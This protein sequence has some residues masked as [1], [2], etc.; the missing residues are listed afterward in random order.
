MREKI[1]TSFLLS[2][3][4]FHYSTQEY[5]YTTDEVFD[6]FNKQILSKEEYQ[7]II[8]NIINIL[9]EVYAFNEII[10]NPPQ[11]DFDTSYFPKIDFEQRLN[12]ITYN[13]ISIYKFYQSIKEILS[14]FKDPGIQINW[15]KVVLNN[16]YF[17]QPLDFY[18]KT[19]N[20]QNK[21]YAKCNIDKKIMPYFA[22][23]SKDI[24]EI[25]EKNTDIAISTINGFEP[26]DFINNFGGNYMSL[27]SKHGTFTYKIKYHNQLQLKYFPL[28]YEDFKNFQI[29]YESGDSFVTNYFFVS[30]IDIY[31]NLTNITKE[32][33][34]FNNFLNEISIKN[35]NSNIPKKFNEIKE[36]FYK[37]KNNISIDDDL[38]EINWKYKYE[39]ILRC[40][41]DF[42]KKIN[43]YHF[44]SFSPKDENKYIETI[45]Q[46]IN[47]F[48]END[49]SI[50]VINEMNEG[51]ENI[52][53]IQYLIGIISPFI[54]INIFGKIKISDSN[55]KNNENFLNYIKNFST[56]NK[57][58]S[59]TYDDLFDN[60]IS[61]DK[62]FSK[63]F[64][65]INK[66]ILIKIESKR[67]E[68]RNKRNPNKIIIYTDL[69]TFST[70]SLFIKYLQYFG[71]AIIVGYLGNSKNNNKLFESAVSPTPYFSQEIIKILSPTSYN[72]LKNKYNFE[73]N[74]ISGIQSFF[75][76]DE[77]DIPLEYDISL[78]D[79][80]VNI[81]KSMDKDNYNLFID[82]AI[83]VIKKYNS[84]C[85]INNKNI[86]K[87]SKGCILYQKKTK[88]N[89]F[90]G[91]ECG[92]DGI[93]TNNCIYGYCEHG[94]VY[95][96]KLKKC[97]KNICID[98][99]EEEEEEEEE[100]KEKEKEIDEEE[101]NKIL[102]TN[103][104][105]FIYTF[106]ILLLVSILLCF[107]YKK[108]CFNNSTNIREELEEMKHDAL[109]ERIINH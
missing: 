70:S 60:N 51:G 56:I 73:F 78:I 109:V 71:G 105:I 30:N 101:N 87:F 72:I 5:I 37:I 7:E 94:H 24:F 33:E 83:E 32:E 53:L 67:S 86:I 44:R 36:E 103:I 90:G 107:R 35:Y 81:F 74:S 4:L 39:N 89:I 45:N 76:F 21:I 34:E 58:E 26:F 55:L 46:C 6:Y 11:P 49:Y 16:F 9:N 104:I 98:K 100:E 8:K 96:D 54:P 80:Y 41:T 3:I 47:Y 2:I 50:I 22:N 99:E 19:I 61:N 65:L 93:W 91:Y 23:S 69:Y 97:V 59:C 82:E 31:G 57:C 10:K 77:N 62:T 12:E 92:D 108:C 95:D 14:D 40:I 85:N 68:M 66:E 29:I 64:R 63:F 75:S 48:D 1:I 102:L 79:E 20:N 42:D 28:K 13:N 15:N 43:I 52:F 88:E 106:F 17:I 38:D 18:I 84:Q 27:K 25:I